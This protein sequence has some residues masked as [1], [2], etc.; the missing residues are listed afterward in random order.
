MPRI[1]HVLPL[2]RKYEAIGL[3]RYGF[4]GL[5]CAFLMMELERIAGVPTAKGKIV[6]AHLGG[7]ASVTAVRMGHSCDTTMGMTP[8]GG[9]MM[10]SRSGDLDPGVG[11]FLARH[12]QMT[13]AS[14]NHVAN[15]ESGMLGISETSGDA[16]V[17]LERQAT[18]HRAAEALEL[19]CYQARKAVAAMAAAIE[20]VDTLIFTGG[21]GEHSTEI[22]ERIC[23]PLEFLG[24]ALD[25]NRNATHA[26]LISSEA[27]RVAVRVLHTDEQWMLAE[28][29]RILLSQSGQISPGARVP[30]S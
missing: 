10:G 9:I 25:P 15:Y 5:S 17:L 22:R 30:A 11:W 6:I 7:G 2:P 19:F 24:V 4:H 1:A 14:F 8:G 3:K 28:E 27:S 12:A 26:G 16:Q 20:G 23:A 29:A 18:D 13:P 21:I